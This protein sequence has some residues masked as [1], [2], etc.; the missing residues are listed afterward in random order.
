MATTNDALEQILLPHFESHQRTSSDS[1]R[2]TP[3]AAR[4]AQ[5]DQKIAELL[6]N[7][8]VVS[9]S[10]TSD[11]ND[12]TLLQEQVATK[13]LHF[14]D[15][16]VATEMTSDST[17]SI[18]CV[19]ELAAAVAVS[20]QATQTLLDRA[21]TYSSVI[22]E[23]VRATACRLVGFLAQYST[24]DDFLEVA[25]ATLLP[26]FTDKSQA[27]RK[28]A[29]AASGHFYADSSDEAVQTEATIDLLEALLYSVQHDPSVSNRVEAVNSLAVGP[30][31]IPYI[32]ARVRDVKP[33]VRLA[34]LQVLREKVNVTTQLEPYQ[35]A[36]LMRS[37]LTD[38]YV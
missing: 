28:A 30:E 32:V 5:I 21:D 34:A 19:L 27:V 12:S 7:D 6:L 20:Q 22:L 37:G 25:V 16:A 15:C 29:I 17:E 3:V 33:K 10:L 31:T 36:E 13:L 23:R 9:L 35:C 1:K 2:V 18:D 8:A 11:S 24:S 38:R 4:V 26:R 14:V